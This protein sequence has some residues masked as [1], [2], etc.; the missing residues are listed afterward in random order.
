MSS[1]IKGI[2]DAVIKSGIVGAGAAQSEDA[3]ASLRSLAQRGMSLVDIIDPKDSRVGEYYLQ[4]GSDPKSIGSVKT[5]YALDSGFGDGYMASQNTEIAP[6]YRR[7]GL[8]R[9]MYDA[10]EEVS[11]NKLVPS[12][13]LSPDGA[14]MWNARNRG[15]LEQVQQR[16]GS[17]NY[18]T[19]E[20]VLRPDGMTPSLQLKGFSRNFGT[21]G[22]GAGLLGGLQSEDA[23]AGPSRIK[24]IIDAGSDLAMDYSSRMARAKDQGFDTSTPYYHGTDDNIDAFD[25]DKVGENT[26]ENTFPSGFW[27]SPEKEFAESYGSNIHE[28]YLNKGV[29]NPG[30]AAGG[31]LFNS[32]VG[33]NVDYGRGIV[34]R[35]PSRIRSVNATFDPAKKGSSN[36]LASAAGIGLLGALGSEDADAGPLTAGARRLIDSRFS[37]AVGGGNE[38]KGV[39]E[40]VE[41]MQTGVDPRLMDTGSQRNLYDFEGS[42]Y[43]LTQSDRSAAGGILDSIHGKAIDPVD[44]RGG[45]DFMFDPSSQGQVWASD[46]GVVNSLQKRASELKKEFGQD[47][48][49]LPYT[50]APTGIDFSTMPLDTMINYARQGMSKANIKKLDRQIKAV[51]PGW[52][53]IKDPASNAIFGKVKGP[54]RKKIADIIDKN[55][56]DVNGGLSISEARAATTDAGQ[57]MEAE[58]TLKNIGRID[59]SAGLIAESGHPTYRGGLPG[60]GIGTLAESINARPLMENN[61]RVLANDMSDIRALSMNHGLSQGVIDEKL[62]KRVYGQADPKL[63]GAMA[64]GTGGAG[65]AA[66]AAKGLFDSIGDTALE[67]MS[68]VNRA[69]A[70]GVNFLTSDQINAILNLSGSDKRIPDLYDIPGIEGGTQGNYME[71]GLLRQIVRQGSEF[72]SPI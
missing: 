60:E 50:M 51:I 70:D 55:Y 44:L 47:P 20:Q 43:I 11:G 29:S 42:P 12:D 45:R 8:A 24:G 58:G 34:L 41:T 64:L 4:K 1:R 49:I 67:T 59:S 71:P 46:P 3:D 7:Q 19:V 26:P 13:T 66:P 65:V 5:D 39:L 68:G 32:G 15:L 40:A 10:I 62:L 9:E 56:R 28:V 63:L 52:G 14:A 21:T 38:R 22:L 37:S 2:I 53:G 17:D 18:D 16:M 25:I 6:G 27:F 61:G 69:V 48:L 54:A 36:L 33:D 30:T 72:L 57:Y 23:E 35:D 31:D